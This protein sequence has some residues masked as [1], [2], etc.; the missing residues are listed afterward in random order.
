MNH[1]PALS[2]EQTPQPGGG[3]GGGA[4]MDDSGNN[5]Q[6]ACSTYQISG[7]QVVLLARGNVPPLGR[8][9]PSRIVVLAGGTPPTFADGG[10]VDVRGGKGVR[11]S[12]GPAAVPMLSPVSSTESTNGV[13]IFV[14]ENQYI[15]IN[16]GLVDGT[17]QKIVLTSSGIKVEGG[18]GTVEIHSLQRIVLKAGFNSIV[19][20]AVAGITIQGT[21]FV[22]I[23]PTS[24][25]GDFEMPNLPAG[26][27]YA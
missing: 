7:N 26:E 4:G 24:P 11:I 15:S 5:L 3:S 2:E 12:A 6:S 1:E 19:I 18:M 17:D 23:N 10:T 25:P 9:A 21:P 22:Q 14:A 27:A 20:D 16:R 8:P 13:E